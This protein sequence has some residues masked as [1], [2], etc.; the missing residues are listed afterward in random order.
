MLRWW[1]RRK[2]CQQQVIRG[3]DNQMALF[4]DGANAPRLG[5]LTVGVSTTMA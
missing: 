3:A 5:R 1:R 4:G 2:E